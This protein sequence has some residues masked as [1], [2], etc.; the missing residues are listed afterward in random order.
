ME[1]ETSLA[2]IR[3]ANPASHFFWLRRLCARYDSASASCFGDRLVSIRIVQAA[4]RSSSS[5]LLFSGPT[6]Q[7]SDGPR[8]IALS[9]D[10][11]PMAAN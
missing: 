8:A 1:G 11:S 9:G 7:P 10:T 4:T 6:L 5:L 3:S 2:R